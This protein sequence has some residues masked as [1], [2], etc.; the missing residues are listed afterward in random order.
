MILT[1]VEFDNGRKVLLFIERAGHGHTLGAGVAIYYGAPWKRWETWS[2]ELTVLW[3]T[4]GIH[5]N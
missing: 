3:W 2:I 1:G 5:S 4:F